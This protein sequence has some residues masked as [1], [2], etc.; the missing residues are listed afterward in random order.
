M[1]NYQSKKIST[2]VH[3]ESSTLFTGYQQKMW[4][5]YKIVDKCVKNEKLKKNR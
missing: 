1:E 3:K 4:I 2:A 5:V